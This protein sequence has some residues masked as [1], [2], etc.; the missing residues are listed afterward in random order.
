M[1][2]D[3]YAYDHCAGVG[4]KG[5]NEMKLKNVRFALYLAFVGVLLW[6]TACG[7]GSGAGNGDSS[8]DGPDNDITAENSQEN[9]D[10]PLKPLGEYSVDELIKLQ[11]QGKI[12]MEQLSAELVKRLASD[13]G[14]VAAVVK[15]QPADGAPASDDAEGTLPPGLETT[16]DLTGQV[17]APIGAFMEPIGGVRVSAGVLASYSNTE[18]VFVLRG[19]QPGA[20]QLTATHKD[21]AITRQALTLKKDPPKDLVL[22][23]SDPCSLSGSVTSEGKP[24]KGA[25]VIFDNRSVVTDTSGSYKFTQVG[26]GTQKLVAIKP[27]YSAA[28]QDVELFAGISKTRDMVI[29]LE[30]EPATV[31]S[32]VQISGF[33]VDPETGKG[34]A[35]LY[36]SGLDPAPCTD[37]SGYF[38]GRAVPKQAVSLAT[39][40]ISSLCPAGAKITKKYVM[41]NKF[42][43]PSKNT[44]VTLTLGVAKSIIVQAS[45]SVTGAALEG[46]SVGETSTNA[47]GIAV[48]DSVSSETKQLSISKDQYSSVMLDIDPIATSFYQV[49]LMP[50]GKV[51]VIAGPKDVSGIAISIENRETGEL[52]EH[53][54]L[55]G[56][57][58]KTISLGDGSYRISASKSG[59]SNAAKIV[60]VAAGS[61]TEVSLVL[62]A[63]GK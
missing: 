30:L 19:L 42:F 33:V 59:Y 36:V 45:S 48:L 35:G 31:P 52:S 8:A 43:I 16:V 20:L 54:E 34:V 11:G 9:T 53:F 29:E 1:R 2:A 3:G 63:A 23:L 6:V 49:R 14:F 39:M 62:T 58:N 7:G 18:G 12:Y 60:D 22:T 50:F 21:Y 13:E 61:Y 15:A 56:G 28:M 57:E 24:L 44:R 26:D 37:A 5:G 32:S 41:A 27:G 25:T 4:I 38:S 40:L 17:L 46:V 47:Q 55:G 51:N 10:V